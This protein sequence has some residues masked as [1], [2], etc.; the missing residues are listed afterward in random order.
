MSGGHAAV[1]YLPDNLRRHR[2]RRGMSQAA[3]ARAMSDC[4]WSWHQQTVAKVESGK[5]A[6]GWGEVIDLA[7]ILGVPADRLS[8]AGPE[9]TGL[10]S[11]DA[12]IGKLR[13]SWD[14][15]AV[16]MVK[17]RNDMKW[18]ENTLRGAE[19]SPYERVRAAAGELSLELQAL[20]PDSAFDEGEARF[21]AARE[22][23]A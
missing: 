13:R 20:H 4:G 9:D 2:E 14:E 23:D 8:W 21:N 19:K 11:V 5:Q 1:E 17:L 22:G 18:A 12:A 10:A 16:A 7:Q 6:P 15:T 3:V